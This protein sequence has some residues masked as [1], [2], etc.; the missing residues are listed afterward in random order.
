M[1]TALDALLR[2]DFDRLPAAVHHSANAFRTKRCYLKENERVLRKHLPSL[3][4]LYGRYAEGLGGVD[5]TAAVLDARHLLSIANWLALLDH[6]GLLSSGQVGGWEARQLFLWSRIRS[7]ADY[8]DRSERAM[9]CLYFEDFLE[10]MIRVACVVALPTDEEVREAAADDAGVYLLTYQESS[11]VE[12]TRFVQERKVVW[13]REPR[14]K[15]W[16][17]LDHLM[18]YVVRLVESHT[19]RESH[20]RADMLISDSE[21]AQFAARRHRGMELGPVVGAPAGS[22]RNLKEAAKAVHVR[23]LGA[24]RKVR[25]FRG[26]GEPQ[27]AKLRDCM[28]EAHFTRGE[29]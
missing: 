6:L 8:S 2:V 3:R 29:Y 19:S 18:Q 5:A 17:C 25:I 20:G 28:V 14:Q 12:F 21:A 4:S 15:V 7:A 24:L 26:M 10:A 13:H 11:P 27:L 22:A 1:A 16:R 9:R 23:L